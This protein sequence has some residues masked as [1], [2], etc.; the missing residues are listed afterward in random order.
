MPVSLGDGVELRDAAWEP[1][2][3]TVWLGVAVPDADAETDCDGER[4]SVGVCDCEGVGVSVCD[5]VD[6][7][8]SDCVGDCVWLED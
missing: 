2:F 1:V 6:D 4:L 3:D 7:E 8:L 5:F